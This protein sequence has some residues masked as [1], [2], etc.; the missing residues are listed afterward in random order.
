MADFSHYAGPSEEWTALEATL[1]A[2]P[3]LSPEALKVVTNNGREDV[4]RE[5]MKLLSSKVHL[6]DHSIP[7]RDG[8]ELEARSYRSSSVDQTTSLPIYIHFHG[9]GFF[10]GTL[11]SEDATC[12]RIAIDVECVVINVNYRHSPDHVHPTPYYDSEDGIK[13]IHSHASAFGGD[14]S[15]IVVGGISAG[16]MLTAAL[17]QTLKRE[18]SPVLSSVKGQVLMIPAV[19]YE[20]CYHP[21]L[22]QLKD[23][24]LSSYKENEFAPILPLTRLRFFNKMLFP[25]SP[26][27]ADRRAN[28]GLATPQEV[29]GLPPAT[30][31]ICGLDPLRDDGLLYA[32]LLH[33]NG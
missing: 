14:S 33:E 16:G 30:F 23:P 21:Y 15:R 8:Q 11:S 24:N 18:Q 6:K 13:W 5:E 27:P 32:K 4:A 29:K 31:G 26:D 9:G 10:F 28:P 1:P 20:D 2:A 12:S 25:T 3:D 7:A 22:R 17:M 19:V